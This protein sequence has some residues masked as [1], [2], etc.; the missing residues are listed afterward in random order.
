MFNQVQVN[1]DNLDD[2]SLRSLAAT[3]EVKNATKLSPGWKAVS[4]I[5]KAQPPANM[6]S[7]F[8][9]VRPPTGEWKLVAVT[10]MLFIIITLLF[11]FCASVLQFRPANSF[12]ATIVAVDNGVLRDPIEVEIPSTAMIHELP[13]LIIGG[14]RKHAL[15]GR[16]FE[17]GLAILPLRRMPSLS[18]LQTMD[19]AELRRQAQDPNHLPDQKSSEFF[20]LQKSDAVHFLVWLPRSQ[21]EFHW[22]NISIT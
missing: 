7:V 3:Q 17:T 20:S 8:V 1:L 9:K 10:G 4:E 15:V 18:D 14:L 6:L 11:S 2:N 22:L 5:W 21:S 16:S 19:L 13:D 12:L